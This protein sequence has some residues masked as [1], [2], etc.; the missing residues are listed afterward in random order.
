[1]ARKKVGMGGAAFLGVSAL[2]AAGPAW[3]Q[4]Q[5]LGGSAPQGTVPSGINYQ[6]RLT[7]NGFPVTGT[8]FMVFRLYNVPSGGS[9]LWTS[10]GKVV[11]VT[12]G[13]FGAALDISTQALAGSVVKYLE[14]EVE[15]TALSP[16]EPLHAVPYALFAR[17]LEEQLVISQITVA[18]SLVSSGTLT[19]EKLQTHPGLAGIAVATSVFLTQ[20]R[21]GLNASNPV[22]FGSNALLYGDAPDLLRLRNG[23]DTGYASLDL[24][25]INL[26]RGGSVDTPAGVDLVLKAG[27][28]A[29]LTAKPGGN[30][31]LG[32]PSPGQRLEVA[33]SV[34]LTGAGAAVIFN[35]GSSMTSAALGSA[36][37]VSN[38]LDALIQGDSDANASGGILLRT[39]ASDRMV[40]TNSGN[41]GIGTSSPQARLDV[42][43][44][45]IFR[46]SVT[47]AAVAPPGLSAPG[48]GALYFDAALKAF[49][50]SE[51][52]GSF[53]PLANNAYCSNESTSFCL[54]RR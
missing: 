2:L 18:V 50:V 3:A 33:G 1:M 45:A 24:F 46:S 31:G 51:D 22:A 41:V 34:K 29:A 7:E 37:S 17:N 19:V 6:G 39:G 40:V 44:G 9:P 21:L 49:M 25:N 10:G 48:A 43:G 42:S 12:Q 13:I 11:A 35:D 14:V 20:G 4:L 26:L 27:G 38:P 32:I 23:A 16:R 5:T 15:G 54:E 8:K 53:V 36:G 30:V 52:G 28:L 47:V